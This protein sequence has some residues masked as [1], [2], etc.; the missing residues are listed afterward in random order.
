MNRAAAEA[1][2]KKITIDWPRIQD[3]QAKKLLIRTAK[4][5]NAET[6]REQRQ[7]NGYTPDFIA[8]ANTP[9]NT[10][11]DAVIIPGPIVFTYRYHREIISEALRELRAA[12]PF[13]SGDYIRSHLLFVNG[14]QFDELPQV[15]S[16]DV[17]MIANT[18]PY[19]RR[20]EIG[21]T[22]SGR[23]F[24]LQVPDRIYERVARN[25]K[26]RYRQVAQITFGYTDLP[27]S[28]IARGKLSPTYGV[29]GKGGSVSQRARRQRTGAIRYPSIKIEVM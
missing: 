18:Q 21:K 23:A 26:S 5:G 10:N 16:G 11:I 24:I 22:K 1:I 29:M 17:V 15:K 7:R 8:Y 2:R 3:E 27:G 13:V 14:V 28:F 4:E 12:S 25:L 20:L 6:L 9:S 19:A